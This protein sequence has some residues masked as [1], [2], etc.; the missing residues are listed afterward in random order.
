MKDTS[1]TMMLLGPLNKYI[2]QQNSLVPTSLKHRPSA[3]RLHRWTDLWFIFRMKKWD[4]SRP[5]TNFCIFVQ[6][7]VVIVCMYMF[8]VCEIV[9]FTFASAIWGW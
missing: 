4:D 7:N 1:I 2:Y 6:V 5:I 8:L 9:N 3:S